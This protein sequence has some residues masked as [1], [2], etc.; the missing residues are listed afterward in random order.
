M[1]FILPNWI[2]RDPTLLEECINDE[3]KRLLKLQ[4]EIS[5]I[6]VKPTN[7]FVFKNPSPDT[8]LPC[9]MTMK[10][11][12]TLI[13]KVNIVD[14]DYFFDFQKSKQPT[15]FIATEHEI[16]MFQVPIHK[17]NPIIKIPDP[18][19]VIKSIAIF[20]DSIIILFNNDIVRPYS[21]SESSWKP[22]I[23]VPFK[24]EI[25][26]MKRIKNYIF[27]QTGPN[28]IS[29]FDST[30]YQLIDNKNLDTKTILE[31]Y[32]PA[33]STDGYFK[34][35]EK[36]VIVV[37]IESMKIIHTVS[38]SGIFICKLAIQSY[39]NFVFAYN[40]EATIK[41]NQSFKL[42]GQFDFGTTYMCAEYGLIFFLSETSQRELLSD[43]DSQN[44][45]ESNDEENFSEEEEEN[46]VN[47][48]L[49]I[50]SIQTGE[51]LAVLSITHLNIVSFKIIFTKLGERCIII[52]SD[53]NSLSFWNFIFEVS[54]KDEHGRVV[55]QRLEEENQKLHQPQNQPQPQMIFQSPNIQ[56]KQTPVPSHMNAAI[57]NFLS[58][59]AKLP[60]NQAPN[61]HLIAD[62]INPNVPQPQVNNFQ[63]SSIQRSS[64]QPPQL[65][66]RPLI[67]ENQKFASNPSQ[68]LQI[69]SSVNVSPGSNSGDIKQV[70]TQKFAQVI[71]HQLSAPRAIH[72]I[73]QTSQQN[74][75]TTENK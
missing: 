14:Y 20:P 70:H 17:N 22:P 10:L 39:G 19:F 28:R 8:K 29:I 55:L 35:I 24:Q 18:N 48:S 73:L 57:R 33:D 60:V 64:S 15:I 4:D 23:D 7:P 68:G 56:M 38:L 41:Y 36:D 2:P 27:F 67:G 58:S 46:D 5:K 6:E 42:E 40:D 43:N 25:N 3:M 31:C 11:L 61:A 47:I 74:Q 72:A 50:A 62:S 45:K 49:S 21:L 44:Q 66:S 26:I 54:Q 53:D 65:S 51:V 75:R 69:I 34:T 71:P 12:N 16:H 1:S 52:K 9:S 32:F 63:N 59:Q 37:N 13:Y 30:T